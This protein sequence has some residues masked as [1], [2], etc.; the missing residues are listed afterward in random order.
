MTKAAGYLRVSTPGQAED[1]RFGLADQR[2]AIES[3]AAKSGFEI[4]GWYADEGI[5]GGTLDRP[6]LQALLADA[7]K[8][9]FQAVVVAKMDRVARDLMAQLWIEKEL[10]KAGVEIVSVA[11]PFRGQDPANVLFRQIIGAFA[12]FEKARIAE[13]MTGGRKQKARQGGYSGGRP[14][15]GYK[16]ARVEKALA[17]D[18]E[19]AETVRRLFALREEHPDWTLQRLA[20]RLN[21]EGHRTKLGAEFKPMTV[22]R[23]LDRRSLY[24]GEYCY[25]GIEVV[26]GKQPALITA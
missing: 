21:S 13:R 12:Q 20:D 1:D 23:A 17:V 2:A 9:E 22:K 26:H 6:G 11:E 15:L 18:E 14:A 5:S 3:Y 25:S 7:A 4:V 19:E 24:E 10:L 8:G 16:A